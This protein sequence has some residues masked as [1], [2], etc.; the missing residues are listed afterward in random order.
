MLLISSWLGTSH[1]FLGI[2]WFQIHSV[3]NHHDSYMKIIYVP[4]RL[5][6]PSWPWHNGLR[7]LSL[8]LKLLKTK[9]IRNQPPSN[10]LMI[11]LMLCY[12]FVPTY[13]P[14]LIKCA[15]NSYHIKDNK[16]VGRYHNWILS[17][18][19]RRLILRNTGFDIKVTPRGSG[20]C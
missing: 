17:L 3:Y 7:L 13:I 12:T 8:L 16:T 4:S 1:R 5:A 15:C 14:T 19:T 9:N 11:T 10:Y 20:N 6:K 2:T 18:Q